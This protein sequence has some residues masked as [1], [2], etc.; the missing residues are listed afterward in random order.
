MQDQV[1]R[2]IFILAGL[3]LLL[4]VLY[5]LKPVVLP[6][7]GAFFIA[8]LFSPLVDVLVKIKLPRWLA[9]SLVFVGIGVTLTVVLWFLVPLVW[10]QLI[11]ARDS[12]PAGIHWVNAT[13]LPWVSHT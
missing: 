11:Y 13:F 8:Y 3:A 6:F 9:I 1:L 4:W 12:I 2:R 7:V 5:L 10:K